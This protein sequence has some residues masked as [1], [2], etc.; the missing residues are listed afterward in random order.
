MPE[1]IAILG[2]PV[3]LVTCEEA[4]RI[5]E[6]LIKQD[7]SH[8]I[9]TLNPE[10]AMLAQKDTEFAKIVNSAAM[11]L[12]DGIGIVW[13][14]RHLGYSVPERVAGYDFVQSLLKNAG[15]LS[16]KVFF[17]GGKPGV[18]ERASICAQNQFPGLMI[19]GTY[20]GYFNRAEEAQ[21]VK[22]IVQAQPDILLVALGSPAQ[23]RWLSRYLKETKARL[24]IG[25]GGTFDVMAGTVRR[26][27]VWM[28]KYGLE[29]FFRLLNQ[30]QRISRM[31]V[32]PK[33][34]LKVITA[35]K[36]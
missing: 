10:M 7:T 26:A 32:L 1:R 9:V 2:L 24:G 25:V 36:Y 33:F 31:L 28:Q 29:W 8:Y 5:A 11:V 18:A 23:E 4:V 27:P 6:Y 30:P 3:D 16:Q 19:A 15:K 22:M 12:P 14:G 21:V 13:A 17:L 20:H 35:K 34:V